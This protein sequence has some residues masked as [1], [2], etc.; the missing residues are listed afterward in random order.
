MD[1][2]L[3]DPKNGQIDVPADA[4]RVTNC[5]NRVQVIG[6]VTKDRNAH[7]NQQPERAHYWCCDKRKVERQASNEI[8]SVSGFH[9]VVVWGDLAVEVRK[10]SRRVNFARMSL[11]A[12]RPAHGKRRQASNATQRKLL[13][14]G[15]AYS[16][17]RMPTR[18]LPCSP[19]ACRSSQR[20]SAPSYDQSQPVAAGMAVPDISYES[21]I[22]P[23]DLPF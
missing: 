14:T 23:E 2:I 5:L 10:I 8:K 13:Q 21:D 22:K 4:K 9:N 20:Q 12:C 18:S 16:A 1:M 11:A 19:T 17:S 6:N 7:H 15:S 3:L